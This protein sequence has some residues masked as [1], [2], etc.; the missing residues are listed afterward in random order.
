MN[1]R[2]SIPLFVWWFLFI[3]HS[4]LR[5][6]TFLGPFGDNRTCELVR[7]ITESPK[8]TTTQCWND[9]FLDHVTTD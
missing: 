1:Y 6:S 8:S 4:S 7:I 9:N 3:N 2:Q 5:P